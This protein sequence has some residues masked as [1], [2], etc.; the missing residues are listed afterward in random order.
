MTTLKPLDLFASGGSGLAGWLT[1]K[2]RFPESQE[3]E[4]TCV[5]LIIV[6]EDCF[7]QELL[8]EINKK[9]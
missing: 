2:R 8:L 3:L 5:T 4:G 1:N 7:K 9:A 6:K